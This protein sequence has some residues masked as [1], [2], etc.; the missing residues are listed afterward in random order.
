MSRAG[1]DAVG[2]GTVAGGFGHW[3][4]Q[5]LTAAALVPLSLWFAYSVVV[6]A[7]SAY[8]QFVQWMDRPLNM[9]LLVV[10]CLASLW[11]MALGIRVVIEDY[12]HG[13]VLKVSLI[14]FLYGMSFLGAVVS[15][16]SVFVIAAGWR[17]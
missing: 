3:W 15:V 2:Q 4:G 1:S 10:W 12:V 7:G 14:S 11:H 6:L 9:I 16:V 17:E 5:R 13:D 8:G